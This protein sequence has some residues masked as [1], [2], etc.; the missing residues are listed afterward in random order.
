MSTLTPNL[1][2]IYDKILNM[3]LQADYYAAKEPRKNKTIIYFHGGGLVYG[4]RSDLPCQYLEQFLNSGYDFFAVDYPLYPESEVEEILKYCFSALNWFIENG[5]TALGLSSTDY[6]LF[7][8]SSGGYIANYLTANFDKKHPMKLISLYSY[9]DLTDKKLMGPNPHY[10]KY[11]A[12]PENI[13]KNIIQKTPISSGRLEKRY[14]I[15]VYLRQKGIWFSAKEELRAKLSIPEEMLSKFPQTFLTASNTDT[16][17]PYEQSVRMHELIGA[18]MFYSVKNEIHDYDR[19]FKNPT[20]Q[21]LYN[22]I[23]EWLE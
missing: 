10:L 23:L 11:P 6:I 2:V 8:R 22:K 12:I 18:S 1:T 5:K 15:Y 9:F 7:G 13:L 20:A 16:D 17:V 21:E 4:S 14:S 19:D 3:D